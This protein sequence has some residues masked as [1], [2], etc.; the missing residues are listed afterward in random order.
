[1]K[2]VLLGLTTA[3]GIFFAGCGDIGYGANAYIS[4][5]NKTV[6]GVAINDYN[7]FYT[8]SPQIVF[9]WEYNEYY[10]EINIKQMKITVNGSTVADFDVNERYPISGLTSYTLNYTMS[11]ETFKYDENVLANLEITYDIEDEHEKTENFLYLLTKESSDDDDTEDLN[12]TILPPVMTALIEDEEALEIANGSG[13]KFLYVFDI[14]PNNST[15]D[16]EYSVTIE[17]DLSYV[18]SIDLNDFNTSDIDTTKTYTDDLNNDNVGYV[19]IGFKENDTQNNKLYDIYIQSNSTYARKN[20]TLLATVV[21]EDTT[22]STY[23]ISLPMPDIPATNA[24]TD[25]TIPGILLENG[26]PVAG[27]IEYAIINHEQLASGTVTSGTIPVL[28]D[29]NF[30]LDISLIPNTS[31]DY[32]KITTVTFKSNGVFSNATI[33]QATAPAP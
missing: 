20:V 4:D 21:D 3:I 15:L 30:E 28:S 18:E 14:D 19:A 9:N 33:T 23:S 22:T 16:E 5:E 8:I 12:T 2:K 17:G 24:S 7:T 6:E 27:T 32:E 11:F 10:K 13:K 31:E 25:I 26:S 29:G 1:M